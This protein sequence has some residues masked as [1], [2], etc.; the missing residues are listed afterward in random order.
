MDFILEFQGLNELSSVL[1]AYL[2]PFWTA[3]EPALGD[4]PIL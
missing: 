2:S 1:D 3:V 4:A